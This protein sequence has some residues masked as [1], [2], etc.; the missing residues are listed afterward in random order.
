MYVSCNRSRYRRAVGWLTPRLE[1]SEDPFQKLAVEVGEHLPESPE[2]RRGHSQTERRQV[3]FEVRLDERFTPAHR[4]ILA[5]RV[6]ALREP[7]SKPQPIPLPGRH[8]QRRK[9][10]ELVKDDP[11]SQRLGG[12]LHQLGGCA[13]EDEKPP[14]TPIFVDERPEKREQVGPALHLVQ[15]DELVG[16]PREI[17]F[18]VCQLREVGR[19]LQIE[20]HRICGP[21]FNQLAGERRLPHLAWPDQPHD[22]ELVERLKQ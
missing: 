18:G 13:S 14:G 9:R 19:T 4:G 21:E 8:L 1:A 10:R 7:A 12:S 5:S 16:L 11:P 17:C 22:G 2:L 3:S 20:H 15:H 6:E